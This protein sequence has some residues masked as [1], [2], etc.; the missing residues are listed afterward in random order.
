MDFMT[1]PDF[2]LK[3]PEDLAYT[4]E[5]N[6]VIKEFDGSLRLF[7]DLSDQVIGM[8]IIRGCYE[9][10]ETEFVHRTVRS[11]QTVLDVGANVGYFTIVMA[12]LVGSS[13]AVYAF[14]PIDV[15]ADL[16]E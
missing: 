16:L 12:S 15:N 7:L 3:N 4:N 11:G 8:N 13:G 1:A 10:T 14:E 9:R 5:S 6:V 2:R